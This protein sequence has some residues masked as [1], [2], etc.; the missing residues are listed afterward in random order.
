MMSQLLLATAVLLLVAAATTDVS[1]RT[2]PNAVSAVLAIDG[3][4]VGVFAHALLPSLAAASCV[5]VPSVIFWRHGLM[6][7]GD[8]KLLTAV[9]LLVPARL[10]PSLVLTIALA[11]GALA[12]IY[13]STR[14]VMTLRTDGRDKRLLRRILRI[15]CHRIRRGF[16]LPYAVAISSGTLFTLS[17]GFAN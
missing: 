14:R 6:G 16:S 7:G 11:G 5:F 10:V 3:I 2:V 4:L 15:E 8:A 17:H 9:S 13:W 12:L 1:L